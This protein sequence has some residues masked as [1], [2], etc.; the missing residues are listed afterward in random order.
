MESTVKQDGLHK[1]ISELFNWQAQNVKPID[2]AQI[3]LDLTAIANSVQGAT[4][5][6]FKLE[7]GDCMYRYFIEDRNGDFFVKFTTSISD[8]IDDSVYNRG[9]SRAYDYAGIP[10]LKI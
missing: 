8:V 6:G 5:A 7:E 10:V 4:P 2:D 3:A 9:V 1:H